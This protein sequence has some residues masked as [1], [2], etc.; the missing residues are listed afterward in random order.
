MGRGRRTF[1]RKGGTPPWLSFPSQ[2]C[3]RGSRSPFPLTR[4]SCLSNS[5]WRF[6]L[7]KKKAPFPCLCGKGAFYWLGL[8]FLRMLHSFTANPFAVFFELCTVQSVILKGEPALYL[9]ILPKRGK[10]RNR[11]SIRSKVLGKGGMGVRGKGGETFLKKGFP[12]LPPIFPY[13]ILLIGEP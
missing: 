7:L 10:A 12:S 13:C 5:P 8:F 11:D 6:C 2:T 1:L 4:L 3:Q 9:S